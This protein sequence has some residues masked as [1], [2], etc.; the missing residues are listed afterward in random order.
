[1]LL[2][3]VSEGPLRQQRGITWQAS[4]QSI[5]IFH[6]VQHDFSV[7]FSHDHPYLTMIIPCHSQQGKRCSFLKLFFPI[8]NTYVHSFTHSHV[9]SLIHCQ[10]LTHSFTHLLSLYLAPPHSLTL[11]QLHIHLLTYFLS[12]CRSLLLEPPSRR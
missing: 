6:V 12:L 3:D 4:S 10:S 1:M 2:V 9:R 5:L 7:I 11:H 8:V